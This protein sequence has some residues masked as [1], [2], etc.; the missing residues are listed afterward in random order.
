MASGYFPLDGRYESGKDL[1]EIADKLSEIR[2]DLMQSVSLNCTPEDAA[3]DGGYLERL[4]IA[5]DY[6]RYCLKPTT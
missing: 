1:L 5:E 2:S 4:A 3:Y 6:I